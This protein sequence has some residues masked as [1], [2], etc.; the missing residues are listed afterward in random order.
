MGGQQ[1]VAGGSA[2][3]VQGVG[4]AVDRIGGGR[5]ALLGGLVLA[6]REEDQREAGMG[7]RRVR[8][9]ARGRGPAPGLGGGVVRVAHHQGLLGEEVRVRRGLGCG[10]GGQQR[11]DGVPAVRDLDRKLVVGDAREARQ[12]VGDEFDQ[13]GV[14][15]R[16]PAV[17]RA[18]F[19]AH[20][21]AAAAH[22]EQPSAAAQPV[23][24]RADR[25]PVNRPAGLGRFDGSGRFGRLAE[26]AVQQRGG[27]VR[28]GGG[29]D[30]HWFHSVH[31]VRRRF[32]RA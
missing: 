30:V 11:G 2:R 27:G 4:E 13:F 29:V 1:P 5:A 25:V 19:G 24:G 15:E 31:P 12:F 28:V 8:Q 20:G 3:S 23:D 26:Q 9:P 14:A 6:Q 7:L 22:T 18:Q 17:R 10:A 32:A 16:M 21:P